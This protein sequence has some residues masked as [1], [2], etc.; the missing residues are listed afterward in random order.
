MLEEFQ[1]ISRELDHYLIQLSKI[2]FNLN[3]HELRIFSDSLS[4]ANS[5]LERTE[6]IKAT[7]DKNNIEMP[8]EFGN[9][10]SM[11]DWLINLRK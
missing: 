4:N 10:D 6:I 5:E 7:L 3:S 8:Y 2:E 11:T 1:N 9:M